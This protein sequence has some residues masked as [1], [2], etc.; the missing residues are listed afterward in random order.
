M[1]APLC[2]HSPAL[3]ANLMVALNRCVAARVNVAVEVFSEKLIC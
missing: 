2:Q 3:V 1:I